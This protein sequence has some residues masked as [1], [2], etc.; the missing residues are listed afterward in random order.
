MTRFESSKISEIHLNEKLFHLTINT[1]GTANP[2]TIVEET[3]RV[4]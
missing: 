3:E 1:E 2:W 4:V